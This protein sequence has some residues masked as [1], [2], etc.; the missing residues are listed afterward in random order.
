MFGKRIALNR[1]EFRRPCRKV[2]WICDINNGLVTE[3]AYPR[4]LNSRN[5]GGTGYSDNDNLAEFGGVGK[6][7]DT[8]ILTC[9][10]SPSGEL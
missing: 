6:R 3:L 2:Q 1:S 9:S 4:L 7:A 8:S 5:S 10:F